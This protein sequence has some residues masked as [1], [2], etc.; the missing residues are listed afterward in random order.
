MFVRP[1]GIADIGYGLDGSLR[2]LEAWGLLR[3]QRR[4]AKGCQHC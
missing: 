2:K 3:R 4:N 1:G